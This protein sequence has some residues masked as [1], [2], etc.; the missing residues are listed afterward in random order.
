MRCYMFKWL[1]QKLA[2]KKLPKPTE[3]YSLEIANSHKEITNS[4]LNLLKH[5]LNF[6]PSTNNLSCTIQRYDKYIDYVEN[7]EAYIYCETSPQ[8]WNC[9]GKNMLRINDFIDFEKKRATSDFNAFLDLIE[10]DEDEANYHTLRNEQIIN[11]TTLFLNETKSPFQLPCQ[12]TDNLLI[13]I[14]SNINDFKVIWGTQNYMN[15][16]FKSQG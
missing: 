1:N 8:D 6:Y 14:D 4:D 2:K 16:I 13:E 7:V 10:I 12:L 9:L 11:Q 3:I 15:L 5:F